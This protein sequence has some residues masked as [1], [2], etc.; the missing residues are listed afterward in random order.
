MMV[1]AI[2]PAILHQAPAASGR[3]GAAV[4]SA[5]RLRGHAAPAAPRRRGR[6]APASA[7]RTARRAGGAGAAPS[8]TVRV[9]SPLYTYGVS[10]RGGRMV[11]APTACGYRSM[12]PGEQRRAG[13]DPAAGQP[14]ARADAG[15]R[16]ATRMRAATT[17]TSRPPPSRSTSHGADAA[18]AH[19]RARG[20]VG[21]D[22]DLHLRARRLPGRRDGHGDGR[23]PERR[24]RCWSGWGR[25]SP[26]PRP[27][28]SENHRALAL[29]TNGTATRSAPTSA[30]LKPGETDDA[31]RPVRLGGGQVEVL[32]DRACSPSTAPAARIS[33]VTA[34]ARRPT[35]REA[36]DRGRRPA[37]PAARRRAASS[38]TRSTPARWS[39]TG[40]GR[41]GHDFDDVNP[42]GWPGFRTIIRPVAVGGALAAGLDAR[43]PGPGLRPGADLLRHPGP[44]AAL[45]AQPEGHARQH[46]DA[47]GAAADEG[48]PGALQ[49]RSAAAAA[50]DVQ[51][52][53]GAQR[54]SV[55]RLLADAA[56]DA[57]AVR[58]LLRV[59]EHD[60]AAGRVVPLAA[61]P[62]AARSAL[63]HPGAHGAVDVRAE[64]GRPDR[65]WSRIR[66]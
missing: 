27:T 19:R 7:P 55:R 24:A 46:A 36:P 37:E 56:A 8:D 9:T 54:Q 29:V 15:R 25:R 2:A 43:A 14:A 62:V 60:R 23:G 12:A 3:A 22:A 21:V 45:A 33:G 65:A 50:G 10:T 16:A 1:I 48:D 58:A 20:E 31:E 28:S 57:G 6:R 53:Q 30:S 41:I 66:R 64:Q 34:H 42:Y 47:G 13:R 32:R 11:E 26:T 40:S 51:A 44:A 35:T 17:G 4:D 52:L 61:G 49:E 18:H 59:P 38:A 39:T 63:H 5:R